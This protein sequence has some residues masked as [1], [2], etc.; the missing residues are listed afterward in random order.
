MLLPPAMPRD[1]ATALG[2]TLNDETSVAS[3]AGLAA[4]TFG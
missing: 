1:R 2:W 4:D 3:S